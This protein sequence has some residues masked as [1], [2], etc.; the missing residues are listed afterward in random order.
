V[1]FPKEEHTGYFLDDDEDSASNE[2]RC[3]QRAS[4]VHAW[5]GNTMTN[6]TASVYLSSTAMEVYPPFGCAVYQ[7]GCPAVEGTELEGVFFDDYSDSFMNETRCLQRAVD[8]RVYC[9]PPESPEA[10]A[11]FYAPTARHFAVHLMEGD[12]KAKEKDG[13]EGEEEQD[14][15]ANKALTS[16]SKE[17]EGGN[18]GGDDSGEEEE[19]TSRKEV[20]LGTQ[21]RALWGQSR[22]GPSFAF[23]AV[24][25]ALFELAG[26]Y[27][28][29][30]SP[31]LP[32]PPPSSSNSG[33]SKDVTAAGRYHCNGP[34]AVLAVEALSLY[35][36][37]VPDHADAHYNRGVAFYTLTDLDNVSCSSRK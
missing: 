28:D 9:H 18:D 32:P 7:R 12:D 11:A 33:S 5:C 25:M 21:A 24:P 20:H 13:D 10:V 6:R 22:R 14:L 37:V 19:D 17:D 27:L 1:R 30:R 15:T 4:E 2:T 34:H 3:L 16:A 8:F 26:E 31:P 36:A 29:C 35:L 23:T